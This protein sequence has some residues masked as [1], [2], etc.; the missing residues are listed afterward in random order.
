MS[1][2]QTQNPFS[3]G[4][5]HDDFVDR[6]IQCE[7]DAPSILIL[8]ETEYP[9]VTID[10]FWLSH[11]VATSLP[12]VKHLGDHQNQENRVKVTIMKGIKAG[13]QRI[14]ESKHD[15][16]KSILPARAYPFI[17]YGDS[18]NGK[19]KNYHHSPPSQI[20]TD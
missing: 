12:Q 19:Q 15:L 1:T 20:E 16:F 5:E 4:L 3:W 11:R 8:F 6:L 17:W 13:A 9:N 14:K 7:E 2:A 18:F 10:N